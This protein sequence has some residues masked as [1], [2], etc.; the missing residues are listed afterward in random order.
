MARIPFAPSFGDRLFC[1]VKLQYWDVMRR[2][3][4]QQ[5]ELRTLWNDMTVTHKKTVT[6]TNKIFSQWM[7]RV[8]ANVV[9]DVVTRTD[10]NHGQLFREHLYATAAST[11]HHCDF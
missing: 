7:L 9:V 8:I 1:A 5:L 6:H 4:Q 10:F 2:R 3:K 11:P